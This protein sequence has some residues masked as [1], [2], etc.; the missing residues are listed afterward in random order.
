[1]EEIWKKVEGYDYEVSTLGNVRRIATG[2]I[3][4]SGLNARGYYTVSLCKNGKATTKKIHRLV[5][6]AFI[7]NPENKECVDHI[8]NNRKN[9]NVNN[10]RWCSNAENQRNRT[11][12][13]NNTSGYKGVCFHKQHQKYM[14]QIQL[15]GKLI[16]IGYYETAEEASNAYKIKADELHK[17]FAKY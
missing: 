8:D 16:H 12:Q 14:A 1:M 17:E 10:L 13:Y 6:I 9:N 3:L 11:K 5:A 15:N 7:P 4:K 2:R